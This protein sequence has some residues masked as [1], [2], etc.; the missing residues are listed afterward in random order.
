[1]CCP[2]ESLL[3]LLFTLCLLC[4]CWMQIF[5]YCMQDCELIN[6]Y[7]EGILAMSQHCVRGWRELEIG[8]IYHFLSKTN[9]QQKMGHYQIVFQKIAQGSLQS[10]NFLLKVF[11]LKKSPLYL[12]IFVKSL[13]IYR[14]KPCGGNVFSSI[15]VRESFG[16]ALKGVPLHCLLISFKYS[17]LLSSGPSENS[18]KVV[19][20]VI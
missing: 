12:F 4:I 16:L 8:L 20:Y 11:R 10:Y 18:K 7:A 1:M 2:G 19:N 3:L 13:W 6:F 17:Q 14:K 15:S 9:I 5:C